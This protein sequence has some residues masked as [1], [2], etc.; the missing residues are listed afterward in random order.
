MR[1]MA[2][3]PHPDD[4]IN[5]AGTL[6]KYADQGHEVAIV[7]VTNGEVG[8]ATMDKV[9]TAKVRKAEA[10]ASAAVIN[11]RCFWMGFQDEFL[12]TG[13][14]VRLEIL[15]V[16]RKFDPDI[17]ICPDKDNDYHPDHISTGQLVWDVRVMTTVPNIPTLSPPCTKIPVIYYMDTVMGI[18]F[19]PE[20]YVDVSKYW[21]AKAKMLACH[22]SQ[23]GWMLDQYDVTHEEF[24]RVHS[25]FRGLQTGCRHAEA[26]RAPKFFPERT[27]NEGL[28]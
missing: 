28:L 6:A 9:Q 21:E 17:I 3:S 4:E 22:V 25:M 11:A 10:F 20:I 19:V 1:V 7:F 18:N 12:Y 15:E 27:R 14:S 24:V 8:S 26:F 16:I 13:E 5:C 2:F 23:Q